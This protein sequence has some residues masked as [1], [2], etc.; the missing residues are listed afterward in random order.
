LDDDVC[1]IVYGQYK[2]HSNN[3]LTRKKDEQTV[4]VD[5]IG[6]TEEEEEEGRGEGGFSAEPTTSYHLALPYLLSLLSRTSR[7]KK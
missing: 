1:L 2:Q 6:D 4:I 3:T 5:V 7:S